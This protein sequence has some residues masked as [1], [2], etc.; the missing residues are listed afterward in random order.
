[1]QL[2]GNIICHKS[3][4][5]MIIIYCLRDQLIHHIINRMSTPMPQKFAGNT[6]LHFHFHPPDIQILRQVQVHVSGLLIHSVLSLPLR[7]PPLPL[8]CD[9]ITVTERLWRCYGSRMD[10][11]A[12]Y[13]LLKEQ[14][15]RQR[16]TYK[17]YNFLLFKTF[18]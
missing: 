1:M 15:V 13:R 4:F 2:H 18:T 10:G 3:F 7:P 17:H 9:N 5:G 11:P 16:L 14:P 8:C 12:M 6:S